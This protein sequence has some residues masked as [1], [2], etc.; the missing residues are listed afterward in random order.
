MISSRFH[1]CVLTFMYLLCTSSNQMTFSYN[2]SKFFEVL[3]FLTYIW[4]GG[5]HASNYFMLYDDL[6]KI[7]LNI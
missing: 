3:D 6:F 2:F 5:L 4:T 7:I 1:P